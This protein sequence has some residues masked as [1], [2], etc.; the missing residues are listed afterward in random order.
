MM[1][2]ALHNEDQYHT[3]CC[4][5]QRC[6]NLISRLWETNFSCVGIFMVI[7]WWK[8]WVKWANIVTG[9]DAND[10]NGYSTKISRIQP[11]G[12]LKSDVL[13]TMKSETL[14]TM[15]LE[16]NTATIAPLVSQNWVG[17]FGLAGQNCGSLFLG[18]RGHT[19]GLYTVCA[20]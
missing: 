9:Y 8:K 2:L 14:K 5:I 15:E 17:R 6:K 3:R 1:Q 13:A 11:S 19:V 4:R 10:R 7:M 12:F 18:A 20:Y 16:R